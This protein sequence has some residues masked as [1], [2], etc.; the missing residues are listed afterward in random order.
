MLSFTQYVIES[1]LLEN[2]AW[3]Q[4]IGQ[5]GETI[6]K[7][8]GIGPVTIPGSSEPIIDPTIEQTTDHIKHELQLHDTS[9]EHGRWILKQIH[10]NK[11]HKEDVP[12]VKRNLLHLQTLQAQGKSKVQLAKL[13]S[14]AVLSDHLYNT[15]PIG[16]ST[17]D[18]DLRDGEYTVL[19]ENEHWIVTQPH[20]S[21]AAC[22]L[23][24]GSN[25][26]TAGGSFEHYS[27]GGDTPLT[28]FIPKKPK[29]KRERYQSW[30]AHPA[31][32]FDDYDGDLSDAQHMDTNNTFI[33]F[34][35]EKPFGNAM[36]NQGNR[37]K[38]GHIPDFST[39]PLPEIT[40]GDSKAKLRVKKFEIQDKVARLR[41][42]M[43]STEESQKFVQELKDTPENDDLSGVHEKLMVH[44]TSEGLGTSPRWR[45]GSSPERMYPREFTDH[46][47]SS[48]H[49]QRMIDSPLG[50]RD[51]ADL[52]TANKLPHELYTEQNIHTI[53]RKRESAS[54]LIG[55]RRSMHRGL[56]DHLVEKSFMVGKEFKLRNHDITLALAKDDDRY[57]LA[58]RLEFTPEHIETMI[59]ADVDKGLGFGSVSIGNRNRFSEFYQSTSDSD[60]LPSAEDETTS[61]FKLKSI[62]WAELLPEQK[63]IDTVFTPKIVDLLFK[64][65]DTHEET[66]AN[67]LGNHRFVRHLTDTHVGQLMQPHRSYATKTSLANALPV[68]Q[69]VKDEGNA[70]FNI[71]IPRINR[72]LMWQTPNIPA[73]SSLLRATLRNRASP[74]NE[75][76]F[77]LFSKNRFY[78]VREETYSNALTTNPSLF[79]RQHLDELSK[80][81]KAPHMAVV[82]HPEFNSKHFANMIN[83]SNLL[84]R[85]NRTMDDASF[86]HREH[87]R[88]ITKTT[89]YLLGDPE[90]QGVI[91]SEWRAA[92]KI[93]TPAAEFESKLKQFR[94]DPKIFKTA[95][96]S[97]LPQVAKAG[98]RAYH[99][100]DHIQAMQH[101][102]D[103]MNSLPNANPYEDRAN[104]HAVLQHI[105]SNANPQNAHIVM[106]L[107]DKKLAYSSIQ[108][109]IRREED[110]P[111][112]KDSEIKRLRDMAHSLD[113]ETQ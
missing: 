92:F 83:A 16:M 99:R 68:W 90:E 105:A 109:A 86:L 81:H 25:W 42:G 17:R 111:F 39:R 78:D 58:K 18:G 37:D 85:N 24:T 104:P 36:D 44:F 14:P 107:N 96:N 15:D 49:L 20:T 5:Y 31:S 106:G 70:S 100:F 13:S 75:K 51:L 40:G 27:Q 52:I 6:L 95:I 80:D 19:G 64:N 74:I 65:I 33:G 35:P 62:P 102:V 57:K 101:A 3:H 73:E 55:L 48:E 38:P 28:I 1:V 82:A 29:Y 61:I 53:L 72:A 9:A 103:T 76:E 91:G 2:R 77:E 59:H 54:A 30:I 34:H 8:A 88:S 112:G 56:I 110:S 69:K 108:T 45:N 60:V 79:T 87:I 23:G 47:T 67:N 84:M 10:E 41:N 7:N 98:W 21:D 50:D 89:R 46:F 32:H 26:C 113:R 66:I 93:N 22:A 12:L 94:E 4:F 71:A 11:M 97:D 43:M 63:Q